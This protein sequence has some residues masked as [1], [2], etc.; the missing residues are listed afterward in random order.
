MEQIMKPSVFVSHTTA[1]SRIAVW[2]KE[3][4]CDL[5]LNAVEFFV[6][7]DRSAIVGGDKWLDR[8]E[9]ELNRASIVLILSSKSSITRPWINFEA[10]GAWMAGKRVI[11]ICHSDLTI[12]S[13]PAPLSSLQVYDLSKYDDFQSL[14]DT[15][16]SSAEL[17]S[18]KIN[19]S[20]FQEFQTKLESP[21]DESN[22][23]TSR[24]QV[25]HAG[26]IDVHDVRALRSNYRHDRKI[27]IHR[28]LLTD[29]PVCTTCLL[30]DFESPLTESDEGWKCNRRGCEKFYSN[31]DF[32]PPGT[33]DML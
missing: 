15:I 9:E 18:P 6:S 31:Q 19:P 32:H 21:D 1:E 4:L 11:P 20:V 16:A 10:G 23:Y 29:E 3:T 26:K 14:V 13:L 25:N 8:I 33:E 22:F 24:E 17:K 27:G 12:D 7:S 28:H 5:L 2:L 30:E